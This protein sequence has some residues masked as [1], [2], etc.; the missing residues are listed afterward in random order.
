MFAHNLLSECILYKNKSYPWTHTFCFT[1]G[2]QVIA[3]KNFHRTLKGQN[4]F[5]LM[6]L[7]DDLISGMELAIMFHNVGSM[8]KMPILGRWA[9][10][11]GTLAP[12]WG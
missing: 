11:L 12:I 5:T 6:L 10:I 7:Y 3:E 9:T 2:R 1:T 8:E 4:A